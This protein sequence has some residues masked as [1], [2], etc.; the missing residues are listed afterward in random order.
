MTPENR[1]LGAVI[2]EVVHPIWSFGSVR[3]EVK[4]NPVDN[5]AWCAEMAVTWQEVLEETV[6]HACNEPQSLI[7]MGFGNGDGP[8]S[9]DTQDELAAKVF[10]FVVH[11]LNQ[12][13]KDLC[14]EHWKPPWSL[15]CLLNADDIGQV[16]KCQRQWQSAVSAE[17]LARES[18]PWSKFLKDLPFLYCPAVRI[19]FMLLERAGTVDADLKAYLESMFH[20]K[21]DSRFVENLFRDIRFTATKFSTNGLTSRSTLHARLASSATLVKQQA[22]VMV[23]E[24]DLLQVELPLADRRAWARRRYF[25]KRGQLKHEFHRILL[26]PATT[27]P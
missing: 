1:M 26:P 19:P 4:L 18:V 22:A 11:L 17:F 10:D 5:V 3:A 25:A 15:A 21:G 2:T 13:G 9:L 24:A 6:Q 12:K 8:E 7:Y 20:R 27:G 14:R 16:A 23:D